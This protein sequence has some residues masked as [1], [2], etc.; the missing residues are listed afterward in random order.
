MSTSSRTIDLQ[1]AGLEKGDL[2]QGA[3]R[4]TK[5]GRDDSCPCGR[6]EVKKC[7]GATKETAYGPGLSLTGPASMVLVA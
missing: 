4:H 6:Q 5:Y 1:S 7:C 3:A 2:D